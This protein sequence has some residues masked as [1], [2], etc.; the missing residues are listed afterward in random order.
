MTFAS[1]F[2]F[3]SALFLLTI[4]PGPFMIAI[5]SRSLADGFWAGMAMSLGNVMIQVGFLWTAAL[6]FSLIESHLDFFSFFLKTLGAAYL[7]YIG[8][9]GLM[10]VE[11][12]V[13][14]DGRG[15]ETRPLTGFENILAGVSIT[16][17]NPFA[18]LFYVGFLPQILTVDT[19][20]WDELIIISFIIIFVAMS[21]HASESYLASRARHVL[22][23]PVVVKRLNIGVSIVFILIALFI[24]LNLLNFQI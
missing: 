18:I 17:S 7:V 14:Q 6:G 2:L 15:T 20:Q 11:S 19:L 10:N 23:N 12:G 21:V 13:W 5:I 3:A 9:R 1:A 8:V 4:K 22:K 24:G 16:L